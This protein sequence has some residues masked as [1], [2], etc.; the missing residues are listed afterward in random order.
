MEVDH[1]MVVETSVVS[2]HE[3]LVDNRQCGII[4]HCGC[5]GMLRG[6]K[7]VVHEVENKGYQSRVDILASSLHSCGRTKVHHNRNTHV[8]HKTPHNQRHSQL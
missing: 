2:E 8:E 5:E 4:P 3:S 1:M 7:E 6:C